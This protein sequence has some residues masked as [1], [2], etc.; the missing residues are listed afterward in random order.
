MGDVSITGRV[1]VIE[2]AEARI[3]WFR[4]RL[5]SATIVSTAV[6]AV[7]AAADGPWDVVFL[8]FDLGPGINSLGAA[9]VLS[10]APPRVCVI[11]SANETGAA[12]I[13]KLF[14]SAWILPFASFDIR[15]NA[16]RK[17]N[18]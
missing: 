11:H 10:D 15:D 14:P 6:D 4:E 13:A 17:R 16:I 3:V 9:T 18:R 7:R 12:E 5:P 1:L 2:D 8:D